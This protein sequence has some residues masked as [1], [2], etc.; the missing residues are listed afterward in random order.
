MISTEI[1][2]FSLS[3]SHL[4]TDHFANV[5][6]SPANGSEFLAATSMGD[7]HDRSM[8]GTTE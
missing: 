5:Y 6:H 2:G 1:Q 4:T 3:I 8:N 7:S